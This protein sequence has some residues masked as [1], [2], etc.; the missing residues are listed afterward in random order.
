FSLASSANPNRGGT[1]TFTWDGTLPITK[2]Y[3]LSR[4]R[5]NTN[6]PTSTVVDPNLTNSYTDEYTAGID[7]DLSEFGDSFRDL[8]LRFNFVRKLERNPCA[9]VNSSQDINSF[10]PVSK[11]DPGPDGIT[12]SADDRN[13]T[14]YNLLPQFVG[15]N[16]TL[17]KNFSGVGSNYS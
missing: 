2:A 5:P 7:Q 9:A 8:G 1:Y 3:L 15:V 4:P 11:V 17:I 6:V 10:T 12:G 13:I 16:N 14:V